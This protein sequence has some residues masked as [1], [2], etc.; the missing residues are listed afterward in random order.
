MKVLLVLADNI[1]LTPYVNFY[2]L[3]LGKLKIDYRVIYWDKNINEQSRNYKNICFRYGKN[4]KIDKVMGYI[5]FREFI[6]NETKKENYDIL[7]PLHSIVSF[8]L[9]D[10]LYFK[11]RYKYVYDVRD[12]S[13]ER[14]W[15]YRIAQKRLIKNSMINIISSRGY[16]A[17]LPKGEYFITHNILNCEY[18]SYKQ[19]E[20]SKNDIIKISYIGLIRFMDQNKKIL[21]F[22]KNDQRFHL[23][24]IGTNATKL[25][26]FC[27]QNK[28][29]NVTLIDTFDASKTLNYY[30]N[31]DLVM[32]LYGNKSP[33]LDYALSNKL[34]YSACLYKPILVCKETYMENIAKRYKIGFI[35]RMDKE[36]EK[37][38]LYRYVTEL[39]RKEF[40]SNCNKFME[41]VRNDEDEVETEFTK[42]LKQIKGEA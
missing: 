3:L 23:N 8:I 4:R 14:F 41:D 17:F 11:F 5:K 25:Q 1:Y 39:N 21:Q 18:D 7:I 38:A 16:Y 2:I 36:K 20:N 32:N 33:L 27:V 42:R 29:Y 34:Y 40:I 26:E 37:D 35:M 24:F 28:I 12:Y 19:L 10:L 9:F 13:Y 31:T 6:I 30:K 15:I 22:F